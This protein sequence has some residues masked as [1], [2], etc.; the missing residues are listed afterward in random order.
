MYTCLDP[1]CC[2]KPMTLVFLSSR[3][4]RSAE[5][6]SVPLPRG[7]PWLPLVQPHLKQIKLLCFNLGSKSGLKAFPCVFVRPL[8]H[9]ASEEDFEGGPANYVD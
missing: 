8:A 9:C 5:G 6:K 3:H 7:N 1:H 2:P 4:E